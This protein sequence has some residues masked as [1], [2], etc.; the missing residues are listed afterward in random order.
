MAYNLFPA[1]YYSQYQM[2]PLQAPPS[3]QINNQQPTQQNSP[4]IWVQ[5]ETGAKSYLMAPNTTLPL[6]DSERQTVYLKSTDASGMPSM[7]ILDYTIRDETTSNNVPISQS[8]DREQ[9][10]VTH[11]ELKKFEDKVATIISKLQE[12]QNESNAAITNGV[13]A[14]KQSHVNIE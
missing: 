13:A 7:K 5:G 6:W 11:E 9:D 1:T 2:Q 3:Q 8:N 10:F 14:K 4:M 12:E